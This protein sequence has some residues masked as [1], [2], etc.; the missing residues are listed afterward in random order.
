[1]SLHDL[2]IYVEMS[3]DDIEYQKERT[4]ALLRIGEALDEFRNDRKQD[5]GIDAEWP[6]KIMITERTDLGED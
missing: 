2:S 6:V 4:A 5:W 3:K 1:M